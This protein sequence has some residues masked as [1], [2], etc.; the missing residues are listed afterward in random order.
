MNIFDAIKVAIRS[1]I[2]AQKMYTRLAEETS[3]EEA[4]ALFSY[5]ERYEEMHQSFLEAERTALAAAKNDGGGR[6]SHWLKILH[7]EINE[8]TGENNESVDQV[9]LDLAATKG[10][11][12]ILKNANDELQNKQARYEQEL[13]IA[14]DIQ[15]KLLPQNIP[16]STGLQ[17][18]A[19]NIMARSVG[20]DYYDFVM[21]NHGRLAL[22]VADTM[23]KG[24]PAALLM[25]NIRAIWRSFA[26]MNFESPGQTLEMINR[27]GYEDMK[28]A[29]A[30]ITMFNATYD[31]INCNFIYSGAGHNPPIYLPAS[32]K[33]CIQLEE[34]G[35]PVGIFPETDFPSDGFKLHDND[36][37]VIYTDGVVEATNKNGVVFGYERLCDILYSQ[38]FTCAQDISD[39]IHS[40]LYSYTEGSEQADDIT[41][42][43]LRKS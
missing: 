20:G 21:D 14:A 42:V 6:P 19:S 8:Q 38:Q 37:I 13:S 11:A 31:P 43:V 10:I 39:A 15:N 26:N 35:L 18:A 28:A 4:K 2:G 24:I 33:E 30:F 40:E 16:Q 32:S 41:L 17:I 34:G 7:D 22:V 23:G 27:S 3:D 1:E 25:T 12:Q 9:Y 29:E 36:I 5:L